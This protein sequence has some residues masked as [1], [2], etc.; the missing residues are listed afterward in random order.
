M[1]ISRSWFFIKQSP[2]SAFRREAM[3]RTLRRMPQ[4]QLLAQSEQMATDL[5]E[6]SIRLDQAA[7]RIAELECAEALRDARPSPRKPAPRHFEWA[8]QFLAGQAAG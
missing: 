2:E 6:A 8:R 1:I 7:N 5:L 3:L 4:A